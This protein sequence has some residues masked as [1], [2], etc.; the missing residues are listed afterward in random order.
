MFNTFTDVF[1]T[2][3]NDTKKINGTNPFDLPSTTDPFGISSNMKL[4][5]S[6]EKFDDNP[7]IV[8]TNNP[9][10]IRPR[11]GKEALSSSNWIAYQHSMDEANSDPLDDLQEKPLVTQSN[12]VNPNNPFSVSSIS[13][14]NQSQ[15]SPF[16]DLFGVNVKS[17]TVVP[18]ENQSSYDFLDFNQ[19]NTS[20]QSATNL[21]ES[22]NSTDISKTNQNTSPSSSFND[23]FL[24][25]LSQTDD[26]KPN[27]SS[28]KVDT[29]AVKNTEDPF[30]STYRQT[31]TLSTLSMLHKSFSF[32]YLIKNLILEETSQENVPSQSPILP[33]QVIRRPSN[34]EVPSICIHEPTFEHND[35]NV[36][37]HGY[38]KQEKSKKSDE[39]SD[40]DSKMVFKIK[41]KKFNDTNISVPLLPPP[42]SASSKKSKQTNDYS[43]S[44]SSEA[45]NQDDD[46]DPL[47]IFRSKPT[48]TKTNQPQGKN[49]ITDWDENEQIQESVCLI[50][51]YVVLYVVQMYSRLVLF[52]Y[53]S[54]FLSI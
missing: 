35:S 4:P 7:F 52:S 45:D 13:N 30:G 23:Q 2:N 11:S 46:D 38:F 36:I 5:E 43:S 44:S 9:K 54:Y 19:T 12:S 3:E 8:D 15:T 37:P 22:N 25:W 41:E 31:P 20:S 40:D 27:E 10:S 21:A 33:R 53:L 29:N 1:N 32:F 39:E 47:A 48:K 42:P 16:D 49:L 34:E 51:L 14:T 50:F 26:S 24:D 28:K 6:S 17:N 18:N